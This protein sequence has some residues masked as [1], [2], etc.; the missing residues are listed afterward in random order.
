MELTPQE[1]ID[2]IYDKM[3]SDE[4]RRKVWLIFKWW[5]RL[6]ILVFFVYMYLFGF[7]IIM[8]NIKTTI[9][10]NLKLDTE[11]LKENWVKVLD[12]IKEKG[13]E[14]LWNDENTKY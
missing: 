5:I 14:L 12:S 10:E 6:L 9:K 7:A 13:K 11:N 4:K 1:K 8:N 2:Y 3:K